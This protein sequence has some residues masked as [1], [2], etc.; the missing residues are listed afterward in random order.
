MN[1]VPLPPE[2]GFPLRAL[3]AGWYGMDSVKWL[4]RVE[5]SQE[6]FQ[7]Y[8]QKQSYVATTSKGVT[9][10]QVLDPDHA[11]NRMID[12]ALATTAP[13]QAHANK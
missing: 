11:L 9:Y 3:V 4:T 6:P 10:K 5:V 2:H 8:F 12:D 13:V 7:G 1:G